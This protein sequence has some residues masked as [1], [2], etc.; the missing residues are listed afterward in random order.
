[1]TGSGIMTG[2]GFR[3]PGIQEIRKSGY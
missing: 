2:L 3:N 1:M